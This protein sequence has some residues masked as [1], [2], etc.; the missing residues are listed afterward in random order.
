MKNANGEFRKLA[1]FNKLAEVGESLLF[2]FSNELDH[3]EYSFNDCPFEIIATLV[4]QDARQKSKHGGMLC[5]K[6]EAERA[7]R[8]DNDDF[9][10]VRD[11]AHEAGDLLHQAVHGCLIAGLRKEY[12]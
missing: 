9:K 2:G 11:L 8:I 12:Q 10:F 1:I 4:A 7:D 3:V 6:L 5:G